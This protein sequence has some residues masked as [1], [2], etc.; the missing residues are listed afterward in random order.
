[1]Q[2]S[3]HNI[4]FSDISAL[5]IGAV[6]EQFRKGK[7]ICSCFNVGETDIVNAITLDGCDSVS[8]LGEAL[9]CGTNCGSCKSELAS[10]VNQ[11]ASNNSASQ[12]STKINRFA[13]HLIPI[14]A[15]D[16]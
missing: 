7:T 4:E 6:P 2:P 13:Q 9:Q 1:M 15:L 3:E 12:H 14:H 16:K 11:H 5:L 10:L 8:A